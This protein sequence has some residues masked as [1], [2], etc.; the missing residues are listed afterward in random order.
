[1]PSHVSV[2]FYAWILRQAIYLQRKFATKSF[3]KQG[4]YK[5]VVRYKVLFQ[6][7]RISLD[8][9]HPWPRFLDFVK[10]MENTSAITVVGFWGPESVTSFT[11]DVY[12][13]GLRARPC[14]SSK[15]VTLLVLSPIVIIT[16]NCITFLLY[17]L[18]VT[19]TISGQC[20]H[21]PLWHKNRFTKL[22]HY[23]CF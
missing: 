12:A 19:G 3:L 13:T 18:S 7:D 21:F 14:Q 23:S 9:G 8:D 5:Q 15:Q 17:R 6:V 20:Y 1:M 10:N 2:I 11:K 16:L 4:G 22:I